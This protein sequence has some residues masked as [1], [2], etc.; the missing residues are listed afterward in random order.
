M[1]AVYGPVPSWRLGRS[2]GIDPVSTR[3]KT[4]SFDCI[5]CQLG[6]TKGP[7]S[8]RRTF[9]QPQALSSE[10]G[11]IGEIEVDYVT[12]SGMAEPTLAAN[13]AELVAVVRENLP[14]KPIAI[15]TNASLMPR[16]DARHDLSLFDVVVA[17]LD[18]PDQELFVQINRPFVNYTLY[19]ILDGLRRFREEFTAKLAL[20][21]MFVEANRKEAQEMAKI[22]REL[23]PEEVQLNT[24][25]RPCAVPP[26]S[27]SQMEEIEAAFGGLNVISVYTSRRPQVTPVDVVATRRRRPEHLDP[28]GTRSMAWEK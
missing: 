15:L 9:V 13:L 25:L 28:E 12:F 11:K 14:D 26:L 23:R 17:K 19:E 5:Y 3:Y 7:L 27:P 16:P 2:L 1:S 8:E 18:A 10:M 4:C 24:P 6:R 20:Q 22:A 21:M